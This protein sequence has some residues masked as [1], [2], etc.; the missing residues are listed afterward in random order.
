MNVRNFKLKTE[1]VAVIFLLFAALMIPC[2]A[3]AA[4]LGASKKLSI[5]VIPE[6]ADLDFWKLLKKGAESAALSDENIKMLWIAPAGLGCFKEQQKQIEWCIK[7]N[8]DAIVVSPVHRHKMEQSL[9][10]A[11]QKGIPVIQMVS[12]TFKDLKGG[13]I[14]S[15]NFEGGVLAANYLDKKMNG[16]GNVILGLFKK[17]NSPVKQRV[18]GFK[19]QLKK[20]NSNLK[21]VKAV[22]VGG[23]PKKGSSKIRIA[24]WSSGKDLNSTPKIKAVVGMNESSSEILI[25]TL[26][27]IKR[28]KGLTFVA[29]NPDS[30]MV[31][32]I[33]DE[34]IS[35]GVAQDPYRIGRLAVTQAAMA[36]R[37]QK[38][39]SETVTEVYLI[40]KENLSDPKIQEI[41]GLKDRTN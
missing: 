37:G 34:V 10:K 31:Q 35:A 16:S 6:R 1:F 18:E 24:M 13:N 15:N 23:H 12:N 38:V 25:E 7:N 2:S 39:P 20:L 41:L 11:L 19:E 8:V 17:G 27:N 3:G 9:R 29:F 22:Y 30:T 40:T 26:K 14:Y 4:D 5:A 36:A 21:V 28:I 32:L 33:Q